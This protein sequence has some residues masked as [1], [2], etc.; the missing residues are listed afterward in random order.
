MGF[1]GFHKH[2][3]CVP[4]VFMEFNGCSRGVS[5]DFKG[6][7]GVINGFQKLSRDFR[8]V[9]GLQ[10]FPRES[11]GRSRGGSMALKECSRAVHEAF[12]RL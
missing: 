10:G 11:E 4:G 5:K 2:S 6:V 12:Q 9:Y 7:P 1:K 8:G 3:R